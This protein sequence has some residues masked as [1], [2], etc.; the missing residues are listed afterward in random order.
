M[1]LIAIFAALIVVML[2]YWLISPNI[3]INAPNIK[4]VSVTAGK[5]GLFAKSD[6]SLQDLSCT[7]EPPTD[8]KLSAVQLSKLSYKIISAGKSDV[9][10]GKAIDVII[11]GPPA[12]NGAMDEQASSQLSGEGLASGGVI[13]SEVW[14]FV[15]QGES[16]STSNNFPAI[17]DYPIARGT[18]KIVVDAKNKY[19]EASESNNDDSAECEG[20]VLKDCFM[21]ADLGSLRQ[22]LPNAEVLCK[23]DCSNELPQASNN[24]GGCKKPVDIKTFARASYP[25]PICPPDVCGCLCPENSIVVNPITTCEWKCTEWTACNKGKQARIC[26]EKNGCG[27]TDTKPSETQ[28]CD[29]TATPN[30]VGQQPKLSCV[31]GPCRLGNLTEKCVDVDGCKKS[32]ESIDGCETTILP[33]VPPGQKC[34]IKLPDFGVKFSSINDNSVS[35]TVRNWGT[36]PATSVEIKLTKLGTSVGTASIGKLDS[37]NSEIV[38]FENV[39]DAMLVPLKVVVDPDD[40]IQESNEG[41]NEA[42]VNP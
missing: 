9:K 41:N 19:G 37:G 23:A 22:L 13:E 18:Y 5:P 1:I 25:D 36:G 24:C 42:S 39:A 8:E 4:G 2:A 31:T 17:T 3:S 40:K 15:A 10:S 21:A 38:K 12:N 34:G 26:M 16:W 30:C 28:T 32:T 7:L 33:Q 29:K 11:S 14:G 27:K 6:L 35:V 20:V